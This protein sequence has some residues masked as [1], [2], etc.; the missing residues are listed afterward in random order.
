[1]GFG[2]PSSEG[3]CWLSILESP[4]GCSLRAEYRAS[5]RAQCAEDF[6][7]EFEAQSTQPLR[8]S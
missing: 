3:G 1:M 7:D 2:Q 6:E 4:S 8:H 5:S